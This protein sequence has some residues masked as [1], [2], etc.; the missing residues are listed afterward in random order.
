VV[1]VVGQSH[2]LRGLGD[3]P[4]D[5]YCPPC[6]GVFFF[7]TCANF[8]AVYLGINFFLLACDHYGWFSQC[9]L[10]RTKGQTPKP[11]LIR[12]TV[13]QGV[14]GHLATQPLGVWFLGYPLQVFLGMKVSTTLE[15]GL[16]PLLEIVLQFFLSS[17]IL[18]YW[19]YFSHRLLHKPWFYKVFFC[20]VEQH[21]ACLV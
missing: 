10:P 16:K 14:L 4:R 8:L 7:L 19:F 2:L 12:K 18:E 5:A 9:K 17:I 21:C 6:S 15:L 13:I 20:P 1:D 3:S 11:A